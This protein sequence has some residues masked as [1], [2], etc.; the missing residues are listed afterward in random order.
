VSFPLLLALF[1]FCTIATSHLVMKY[2]EEPS[3]AWLGAAARRA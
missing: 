2:V 3:R 1:L